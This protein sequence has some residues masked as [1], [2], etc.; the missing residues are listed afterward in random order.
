MSEG[1]LIVGSSVS[2]TVTVKLQVA[3]LPLA[4]VT[5]YVFVVTPIG[6]TEPLARPDVCTVLA[7][8]QLSLPEGVV[9]VTVAPHT[10]A[11]LLTV[12]FE[13]Q[14]IVG[15]SVSLTVTVKL[16]VAVLPL[17]SV[18]LNVLVV[19]PIGNTDPLAR[20]D[21]CTVLALG[22][23]SL[24]E[25][26]VYVT[27]APHTP[28][29]LLTVTLEGQ[30]IVG[31]SVSLT[32][33]VKLHVAVLPFA[34]VTL[35]VFVVTPIGKIDPL[36]WPDVCTV[37]APGQLSVPTGVV[38]VTVAPHTPASLLTTMLFGQLIDGP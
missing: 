6:K 26:V 8:G 13:G 15:S 11:S 35:Y 27:V 36:A 12:M 33:T 34:S 24:P 7:P 9:Y 32:V 28:A 14:L 18:T 3:V 5:L 10:P 19:A 2:F 23:L 16:H 4:S 17:A 20:P 38:Y 30:L 21:V 29:S 22:Q 1:Q 25:G 31:S 37:L